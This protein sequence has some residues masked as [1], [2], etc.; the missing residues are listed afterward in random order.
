MTDLHPTDPE[1]EALYTTLRNHR[2][3]NYGLLSRDQ[4]VE[5]LLGFDDLEEKYKG[6]LSSPDFP[7]PQ[8]Q[9]DQVR[10]DLAMIS[11]E[12]KE[13]GEKDEGGKLRYEYGKLHNEV[14]QAIPGFKK[15]RQEE[16]DEVGDPDETRRK[17][18]F[19]KPPG[20]EHIGELVDRA[21]GW[22]ESFGKGQAM[23]ANVFSGLLGNL[24][25][26]VTQRI[27]GG[28]RED[29]PLFGGLEEGGWIDRIHFSRLFD[30]TF[31][32]YDEG[33]YVE[34]AGQIIRKLAEHYGGVDPG[35]KL[36][37]DP[38]NWVDAALHIGFEAGPMSIAFLA[39]SL[40]RARQLYKALNKAEAED[41]AAIGA[42]RYMSGRYID[43]LTGETR[44]LPGT[45]VE[46]AEIGPYGPK[47][48]AIFDRAGVSYLTFTESKKLASE[49]IV[50]GEKFLRMGRRAAAMRL[51]E[52]GLG[53][54]NFKKYGLEGLIIASQVSA[55]VM[56]PKLLEGWV[57]HDKAKMLGEVGGGFT[58]AMFH[59]Q[60]SRWLTY[61]H[62]KGFELFGKEEPAFFSKMLDIRESVVETLGLDLK[63][64]KWLEALA[65]NEGMWRKIKVR[66]AGGK[67]RQLTDHEKGFFTKIAEDIKLGGDRSRIADLEA[68]L[69][70]IAE[71]RKLP[72]MENVH[73][74][75]G[76]ALNSWVLQALT[77][78]LRKTKLVGTF[79]KIDMNSVTESLA[80]EDLRIRTKGL[81]IVKDIL[82][83]V[84]DTS[85]GTVVPRSAT[86][87]VTQLQHMFITLK[88]AALVDIDT[89]FATS[90]AREETSLQKALS[91]DIQAS[92]NTAFTGRTA[93]L[94][95]DVNAP[96]LSKK[97]SGE[98]LH[99]LAKETMEHTAERL[100]GKHLGS[101]TEV[102]ASKLSDVVTNSLDSLD[103]TITPT[104]RRATP[105][106]SVYSSTLARVKEAFLEAEQERTW[107]TFR[108]SG[109]IKQ[110]DFLRKRA[111]LNTETVKS[112][113]LEWVYDNPKE[114]EKMY[115]QA[116]ASL[117]GELPAKMKVD[118]ILRVMSWASSRA[119]RSTNPTE[120]DE[121]TKV[122]KAIND[123]LDASGLTNIKEFRT[124]WHEEIGNGFYKAFDAKFGPDNWKTGQL[125]KDSETA[126]KILGYIKRLPSE[127]Q[128]WATN[129]WGVKGKMRPSV[130]RYLANEV[131]HLIGNILTPT[132]IREASKSG[133]FSP[134]IVDQLKSIVS[135]PSSFN[136][137]K[138]LQRYWPA[139]H[140]QINSYIKKVED[141]N[142]AGTLHERRVVD[143]NLKSEENVKIARA[144]SD[145]AKKV[146]KEY[147]AVDLLVKISDAAKG[148]EDA[149]GDYLVKL[150]SE[151]L[152]GVLREIK[153]RTTKKFKGKHSRFAT[154]FV[155]NRIRSVIA[156]RIVGMSSELLDITRVVDDIGKIKG[157]FRRAVAK[158]KGKHKFIRGYNLESSMNIPSFL[159]N[160]KSH[161]H[162][163]EKLYTPE[164]FKKIEDLAI[165]FTQR[166]GAFSKL[167]AI[168]SGVMGLIQG[169][170]VPMLQGRLYSIAKM[171]LSKMYFAGEL[172]ARQLLL[173]RGAMLAFTL[174]NPEAAD[175]VYALLK[176]P[177]LLKQPHQMTALSRSMVA[178]ARSIENVD[179]S[180]GEKRKRNP[181]TKTWVK[182]ISKRKDVNR[183]AKTTGEV[184]DTILKEWKKTPPNRRFSQ[185]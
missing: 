91:R 17:A 12:K 164:E 74:A 107:L 55:G 50:V 33:E 98:A 183:A 24:P 39:P 176:S 89:R 123:G 19:A 169:Y 70:N 144:S 40:F 20:Q 147:R 175:I 119:A 7:L 181:M 27:L 103:A 10:N 182:D 71:I 48:E 149:L 156:N 45:Y 28:G 179:L 84:M 49:G 185:F 165:F 127:T 83:R 180:A 79:G 90:L 63:N 132:V 166:E 163:L 65:G 184:F 37:K 101:V 174:S 62:R 1:L 25:F 81:Q 58:M 148:G 30:P 76:S 73:V 153:K 120:A 158:I 109:M 66:D 122:V 116:V 99:K 143:F 121:Y 162:I 47:V 135:E 32:P 16:D 46:L 6:M 69:N 43:D 150:D 106:V 112:T 95:A 171:K 108:D 56:L 93:S 104:V 72:G 136:D 77:R 2:A 170:T 36:Y 31:T 145:A 87:A 85:T 75:L 18:F 78:T 114:A 3:A 146:S 155:E 129:L 142:R 52:S 115:A 126:T 23:V 130:G 15:A 161:K 138:G 167:D 128:E 9:A 26:N 53:L 97:A 42:G 111:G 152:D 5:T 41:A 80:K 38:A 96:K 68:S 110:V 159:Q 105:R 21:A 139:I 29:R 178:W 61:P 140:E 154:N 4:K 34:G 51:H 100:R 44:Y 125:W 124:A 177:H 8:E 11:R 35:V 67:L 160:F 168:A 133:K 57:G 113:L 88:K 92:A 13:K 141:F 137:A 14:G 86:R 117:G 54:Y 22:G 59:R 157:K 172:T 60:L 151:A 134:Q 82:E 118:D 131:E 94:L 173:N 64:P 102:E